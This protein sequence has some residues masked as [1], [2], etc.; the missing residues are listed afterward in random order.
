[1]RGHRAS[2]GRR[3]RPVSLRYEHDGE[4]E[5]AREQCAAT[6]AAIELEVCTSISSSRIFFMTFPCVWQV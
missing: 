1:M 6:R 5:P 4:P 2:R 3:E